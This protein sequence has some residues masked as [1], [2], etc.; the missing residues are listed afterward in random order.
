MTDEEMNLYKDLA[1]SDDT[2]IESIN[3]W[4]KLI[5]SDNYTSLGLVDIIDDSKLDPSHHPIEYY[6]DNMM[7]HMSSVSASSNLNKKLTRIIKC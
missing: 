3:I 1:N 6:K 7:N 2:S 5:G 4:V